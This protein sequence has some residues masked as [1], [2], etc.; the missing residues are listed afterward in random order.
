MDKTE[1]DLHD[2]FDE[3]GSRYNASREFFVFDSKNYDAVL[4][5]N[6]C[7]SVMSDLSLLND[8]YEIFT[9]RAFTD[10]LE[11]FYHAVE[12]K[13]LDP[14]TQQSVIDDYIVPIRKIAE[15]YRSN[16]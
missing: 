7:L 3:M 2:M 12:N 11:N 4:T 10:F 1:K 16:T 8:E 5:H 14:E 9:V 15:E 13:L 6:A